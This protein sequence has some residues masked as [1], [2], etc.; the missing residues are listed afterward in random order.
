MSE[1]HAAPSLVTDRIANSDNLESKAIIRIKSNER[2]SQLDDDSLAQTTV[3]IQI[4]HKQ[5]IN[6]DVKRPTQPTIY[7]TTSKSTNQK[8]TDDAGDESE[9]ELSDPKQNYDVRRRISKGRLRD[10]S[11]STTQP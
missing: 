7:Q 6:S 11:Q 10:F 9:D 3:D 5:G 2:L 1:T 8:Y 4:K